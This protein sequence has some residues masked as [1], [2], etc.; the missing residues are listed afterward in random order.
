M[1][2]TGIEFFPYTFFL[3]SCNLRREHIRVFLIFK[4][5]GKKRKLKDASDPSAEAI[6]LGGG[7]ESF[8]GE[9]TLRGPQ[10]SD[11]IPGWV[12]L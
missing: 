3:K 10:N 12:K 1:W 6:Q 4:K 8:F 5:E 9:R 7:K 2:K 11:K